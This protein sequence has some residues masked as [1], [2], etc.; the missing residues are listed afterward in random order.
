MN[1]TVTLVINVGNDPSLKVKTTKRRLAPLLD[2]KSYALCEDLSQA[3][4][5]RYQRK[6]NNGDARELAGLLCK[7]R[8]PLLLGLVNY[9]EI[10]ITYIYLLTT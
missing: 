7:R 8:N 10:Q 3:G 2:I 4:C 5:R 1:R 6:D 9:L